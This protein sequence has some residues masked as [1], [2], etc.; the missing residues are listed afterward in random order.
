M[1]YVQ[2]LA[3]RQEIEHLALNQ[4]L[5]LQYL[6]QNPKTCIIAQQG[7][8]NL[9]TFLINNIHPLIEFA[10]GEN[11][12]LNSDE[13]NTCLKFLICSSPKFSENL[14]RRGEVINHIISLMFNQ[15][16]ADI[17]FI[18]SIHIIIFMIKI[19]QGYIL[20]SIS[21]RTFFLN[22]VLTLNSSPFFEDLLDA[23]I[24]S[25]YFFNW[26]LQI[27]IPQLIGSILA[28]PDMEIFFD[29][30][31]RFLEII[32]KTFKN[33]IGIIQ[34]LE[35][36][37]YESLINIGVHCLNHRALHC[38]NFIIQTEE[39]SRDDS[40]LFEIIQFSFTKI[41]FYIQI[42][43][44]SIYDQMEPNFF[45]SLQ[46]EVLKN[47]TFL[48]HFIEFSP[49]QIGCFFELA[50][51]LWHRFFDQPTN[52]FLHN[53]FVSLFKS[54]MKFPTIFSTFLTAN[55]F[56][57]II[58]EIC[59]HKP[60]ASYFGQLIE[61]ANLINGYIKNDSKIIPDK[62]WLSF[63]KRVLSLKNHLSPK[64][65]GGILPKSNCFEDPD[66][67]LRDL[68][69]KNM[70]E[71]KVNENHSIDENQFDESEDENGYVIEEEEEEW[72]EEES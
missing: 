1:S 25:K 44:N 36:A 32:L 15:Q 27:D 10:I 72:I 35:K 30:T 28:N 46:F 59:E 52:S 48:L 65:Y 29:K 53:S 6:F 62:N 9:T 50:S 60:P 7:A 58:P 49:D 63:A 22:Q 5:T 19:S 39:N 71:T 31:I 45:Q 20:D 43:N 56:M 3:F 17:Y 51:D 26:L 12:S 70:I 18:N 64:S 67:K 14:S 54:L 61:L 16:N 8:D 66:K 34:T 2:I 42:L 11:K 23:I 57:V 47:L 55:N 68:L 21:D 4:Q 69:D 13:L 37:V 38:L 41:E 40:L 33:E 24:R